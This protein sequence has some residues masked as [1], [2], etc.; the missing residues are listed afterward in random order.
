M[1]NQVKMRPNSASEAR[2]AAEYEQ[3][4]RRDVMFSRLLSSFKNK[5]GSPTNAPLYFAQKV[6]LTPT[7]RQ[8]AFLFTE[9]AIY[10]QGRQI[11]T[12]VPLPDLLVMFSEPL[13]SC[14]KRTA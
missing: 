7:T 3:I 12:V 4:L 13:F 5:G 8:I 14:I 2:I 9:S 10:L 1:E 11:V 6:F